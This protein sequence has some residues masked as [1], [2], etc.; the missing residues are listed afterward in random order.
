M[1]VT[2]LMI[3]T[4]RHA[5]EGGETLIDFCTGRGADVLADARSIE[6]PPTLHESDNFL[7][8][9]LCGSGTVLV[10]LKEGRCKAT[11]KMEFKLPWRE[12]G[13]LKSSR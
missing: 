12:A 7:V 4:G 13:P 10:H 1:G 11:W 2:Y 5:F 9:I 3:L 8:L 6:R